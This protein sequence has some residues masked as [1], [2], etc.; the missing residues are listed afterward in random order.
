[1]MM[2]GGGLRL[3]RAAAAAAAADGASPFVVATAMTGGAGGKRIQSINRSVSGEDNAGFALMSRNF[4]EETG[5]W[6][7]DVEIVA[8]W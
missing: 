6:C 7:R 8:G 1:M 5:G 4:L 2:P 3:S